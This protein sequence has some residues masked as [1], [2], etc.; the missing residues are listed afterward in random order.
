MSS[1][2]SLPPNILALLQQTAQAQSQQPPAPPAP[3]GM[4]PQQMVG[5]PPPNTN[6][7]GQ[8]GYQ[9]LMAYLVS[10]HTQITP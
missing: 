1:L 6:S 7:S 4:P 8:Q 2:G 10:L 3:Y 5:T 9:Q